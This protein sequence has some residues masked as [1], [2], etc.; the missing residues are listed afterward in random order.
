MKRES[1]LTVWLPALIAS[2]VLPA[3]QSNAQIVFDLRNDGG[4][5]DIL[6]TTRPD[7]VIQDGITVT[8]SAT[9]TLGE[10]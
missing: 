3:D 10:W 8:A 7:P 4:L 9:T 1:L 2:M 5:G 6:E